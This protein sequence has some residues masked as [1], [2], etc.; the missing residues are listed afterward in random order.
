MQLWDF[1]L[2]FVFFF[3]IQF[4]NSY[5]GKT[6]EMQAVTTPHAPWNL[7]SVHTLHSCVDGDQCEPAPCQN[8]GVCDDGV[9][10]Y[11]CWCKPNFSGKNC[12]IGECGR[13]DLNNRTTHLMTRNK[14]KFCF[15][16]CLQRWTS[17]VPS[18]TAGVPISVWCRA[19]NPCVS[20]QLVTSSGQTREAVNK[21]VG[22]NCKPHTSKWAKWLIM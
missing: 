22:Y 7:L 17:S 20:V 10:T 4:W 9:G 1:S 2:T 21:Q 8:G 11:T 3:Q 12:E 6:S 18:T 16:S 19:T 13:L 5:I 15:A 14:E